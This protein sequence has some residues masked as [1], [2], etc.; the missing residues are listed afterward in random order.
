MELKNTFLK[1]KNNNEKKKI[2]IGVYIY[3]SL[4]ALILAAKIFINTSTN[5]LDFI[6][7]YIY[8]LSYFLMFWFII[9][10]SFE[11]KAVWS[12]FFLVNLF[13]IFLF[14]EFYPAVKF[15]ILL[16]II[17]GIIMNHFQI[18]ELK[19]KNDKIQYLSYHDGLTGVHN[20]RYFQK[21]MKQ[22][23]KLKKDKLSV[24]IADINNL[25]HIND[26]FGHQKGDQYIKTAAKILNSELR[27]NDIIAR[28]G[29]DEFAILLPETNY[30][31][32]QKIIKRF[33]DKIKNQDHQYFSIAFGCVSASNQFKNMEQII[34]QAD[35]KMYHS[36]EKMKEELNYDLNEIY[37]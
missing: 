2:I 32:C 19:E 25:K 28:I 15:I 34:N 36:K 22:M 17:Y 10:Q 11:K 12:W 4:L 6:Y 23:K 9:R 5:N 16:Q 33:K 26:S 29:G 1:N 37:E 14:F 18:E 8:F 27:K 24:I 30:E 13:F 7:G 31:N 20:R 21:Q 35:K 3:L